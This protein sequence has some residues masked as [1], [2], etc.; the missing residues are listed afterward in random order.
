MN[1]NKVAKL[2]A[3][4][5]IT[6]LGTTSHNDDPYLFLGDRDYVTVLSNILSNIKLLTLSLG[7][8]LVAGVVGYATLNL[9][10]RSDEQN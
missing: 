1:T 10:H 4:M 6:I 8:G 7:I 5:S 3:I 9:L 2:L